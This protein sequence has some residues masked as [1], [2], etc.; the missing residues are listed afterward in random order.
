MLHLH[1]GGSF[2]QFRVLAYVG[3]RRRSGPQF[4]YARRQHSLALLRSSDRVLIVFLSWVKMIIRPSFNARHLQNSNIV[5]A[6]ARAG[7]GAH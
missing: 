5:L 6:G 7:L 2:P 1:R 4:E 3:R